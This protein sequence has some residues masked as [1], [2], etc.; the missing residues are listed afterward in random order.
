MIINNK[1]SSLC[2]TV[3]SLPRLESGSTVLTFWHVPFARRALCWICIASSANIA[4]ILLM[5]EKLAAGGREGAA[6]CAAAVRR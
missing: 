6:T 5:S 2:E 1:K 3:V 4:K